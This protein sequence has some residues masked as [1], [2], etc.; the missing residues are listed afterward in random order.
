MKV[1]DLAVPPSFCDLYCPVCGSLICGKAEK[2]G[3]VPCKHVLFLHIDIVG[4]V[5]TAPNCQQAVSEAEEADDPIQFVLDH[6]DAGRQSS[7]LCFSTTSDGVAC[8]PCSC[9]ACVAID[10]GHAPEAERERRTSKP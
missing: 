2:K 4:F 10:F 9:T 6:L 3:H 1:I 8:G 7:T 5:H